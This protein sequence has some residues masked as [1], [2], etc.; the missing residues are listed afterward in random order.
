[1]GIAGIGDVDDGTGAWISLAIDEEIVS[2]R[3]GDRHHTALN[4][5]RKLVRRGL[6]PLALSHLHS[7][8]LDFRHT[9]TC[10]PL[11]GGPLRKFI[12]DRVDSL[13]HAGGLLLP[14]MQ[15]LAA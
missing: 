11:A 7:D 4:V 5:T 12:F 6:S 14:G 9:Y 1:F 2:K 15:A 8:D 10:M 13:G 3:L